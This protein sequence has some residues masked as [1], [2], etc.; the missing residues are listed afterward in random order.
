MRSYLVTGGLGFIGSHFVELL[1][2]KN[3]D[4]V[5]L[6]R[7]LDK[8]TYA[9]NFNLIAE[10]KNDDRFQFIKGDICS[11]EI[12]KIAFENVDYVINFAAESHVD[13]SIED[14][15]NFV[16]TNILGVQNLL[17]V[18]LQ[19][20]I[21]KFVQISTDE[22]YGSL[23][24]GSSNE[25][26]ILQPSSPYAASKA[27][28]DLLA[29]SFYITHQLPI[30]ITRSCNNYGIRQF[31]EKLIPLTISNLSSA[32]TVPIFGD[33][34]N[35]REWIH[36]EDH[37]NAIWNLIQKSKN[38]EIYNLGSGESIENLDLVY[39]I[40]DQ[41]SASKKNLSFLPDR[42]GH[43]F[44]YSLNSDKYLSDFRAI[45]FRNL[46]DEIPNLVNFYSNKLYL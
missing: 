5:K 4:E 38:G 37:C 40:C 34:K 7:V 28:A 17:E 35:I 13:R 42:K 2:R 46:L 29:R 15:T 26:D 19:F 41:M 18:A 31:P 27:S 23:K 6:V 12:A 8:I 1:L 24:S 43:D 22:V 36:V 44:R 30:L 45:K 9:A 39:N 33:G 16:N 11:R 32:L 10:F 20:E 3:R 21:L 14:S 25:D